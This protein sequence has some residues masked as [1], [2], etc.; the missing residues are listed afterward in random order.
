MPSDL[1]CRGSHAAVESLIVDAWIDVT[2]RNMNLSS[3]QSSPGE[4]TKSDGSSFPEHF[5]IGCPPANANPCDAKVYR[6]VRSDPPT[7]ADFLSQFAERNFTGKA[8]CNHC[9]LSIFGSLSTAEIRLRD[10]HDK[11]PGKNYHR[12]IAEGQVIPEH[13]KTALANKATDHSELWLYKGVDVVPIFE[14]VWELE[15]RT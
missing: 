13:G 7:S 4:T 3:K 6:F 14:V 15:P 9:S 11:Y 8:V 5:P 1:P 10:L 12:F 2:K